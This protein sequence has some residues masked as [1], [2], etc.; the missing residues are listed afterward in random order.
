MEKYLSKGQVSKLEIK[1]DPSIMGAM[2]VHIGEKYADRSVKT[3]IQK[4][5]RAMREIF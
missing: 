5:S 1:I 3:K 2:I 4:L